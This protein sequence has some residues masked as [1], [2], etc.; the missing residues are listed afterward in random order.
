MPIRHAIRK[1]AAQPVPFVES[2]PV[3]EQLL[4]EMVIAAPQLLSEGMDIN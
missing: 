3:T 4:K 1:V 2:W